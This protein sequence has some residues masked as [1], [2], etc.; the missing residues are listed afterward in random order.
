MAE[1]QPESQESNGG[2]AA[3]AAKRS[4][5]RALRAVL[6]VVGIVAAVG[7][8]YGNHVRRQLSDVHARH[9]RLL[10]NAADHVEQLLG[11]TYQNVERVKGELENLSSFVRSQPYLELSEPQRAR[12]EGRVLSGAQAHVRFESDLDG[13]EIVIGGLAR[14]DV[15]LRPEAGGRRI[16]GELWATAD[17]PAK[18]VPGADDARVRLENVREQLSLDVPLSA[19][20]ELG[21]ETLSLADEGLELGAEGEIGISLPIEGVS[22]SFDLPAPLERSPAGALESRLFLLDLDRPQSPE[23]DGESLAVRNVDQH[24]RLRLPLSSGQD[25]NLRDLKLEGTIDARP[26]AKDCGIWAFTDGEPR[27]LLK[28]EGARVGLAREPAWM[29]GGALRWGDAEA[30]RVELWAWK[31]RVLTDGALE[32][33]F[34][35][36]VSL[37]LGRKLPALGLTPEQHFALVELGAEARGVPPAAE[38][39]YLAAELAAAFD[40]FLNGLKSVGVRLGS[41]DAA[42][43]LVET[44]IRHERLVLPIPEGARE[45]VAKGP[46]D[47]EVWPL[48]D[49]SPRLRVTATSAPRLSGT[50]EGDDLEKLRRLRKEVAGVAPVGRLSVT[51]SLGDPEEPARYRLRVRGTVRHGVLELVSLAGKLPKLAEQQEGTLSALIRGNRL[52]RLRQQQ[53]DAEWERLAFDVSLKRLL[54]AL[55]SRET[56]PSYLIADG[57]GEVLIQTWEQPEIGVRT[58]GRVR[59]RSGLRFKSVRA[60]LEAE[61]ESQ[62]NP[63]IAKGTERESGGSGARAMRGTAVEIDRQ[64]A[65]IPMDLVCQPLRLGPLADPEE[66]KE[67][68]GWEVWQLCGLIDGE[69]A[70]REALVVSPYLAGGLG[71]LALLALFSMPILRFV[72]MEPH[73]RLRRTELGLLISGTWCLL[74]VVSL[75]VSAYH[76]HADFKGVLDAQLEILAAQVEANLTADLVAADELL[77]ILDRQAATHFDDSWLESKP[78]EV[79]LKTRTERGR[80]GLEIPGRFKGSYLTSVFWVDPS[81]QQIA[82]AAVGPETTAMISVEGREYFRAARGGENWSVGDGFYFQTYSSLTT[83]A[84]SAALARASTL[85]GASDDERFVVALTGIPPSVQDPLV[86]PPLGFAVI[87]R[88]GRT[89]FHSDS[90]R[91]LTANFFEEQGDPQ[92]LAAAMG[93]RTPVSLAGT[94][95]TR[96][97]ILHVRPLFEEARLPG[98]LPEWWIVTFFDKQL[99]ATIVVEAVVRS[100]IPTLLSGLALG[101]ALVVFRHVLLRA[102]WPSRRRR[103]RYRRIAA[104]LLLLALGLVM[105]LWLAPQADSTLQALFWFGLIPLLALI[106]TQLKLGRRLPSEDYDGKSSPAAKTTRD[107]GGSP[108]EDEAD[109]HGVL[110]DARTWFAEM[111]QREVF[112]R[113]T[114]FS[115]VYGFILLWCVVAILPALGY[116]EYAWS[117]QLRT[118]LKHDAMS[119]LE[120]LE[121]RDERSAGSAVDRADRDIYLFSAAAELLARKVGETLEPWRHRDWTEE[122]LRGLPT[123]NQ[124]ARSLR[125]LEATSPQR[126]TWVWKPGAGELPGTGRATLTR[127]GTSAA[128]TVDIPFHTLPGGAAGVEDP[129]HRLATLLMLGVILA[130]LAAWVWYIADRICFSRLGRR[131]SRVG[132]SHVVERAMGKSMMAV[133][134]DPKQSE[135]LVRE[136]RERAGDRLVKVDLAEAATKEDVQAGMDQIVLCTGFDDALLDRDSRSDMRKRL[137]RIVATDA[138]AVLLCDRSSFDQLVG[139]DRCLPPKGTTAKGT[140]LSEEEVRAWDPLLERF[141]RRYVSKAGAPYFVERAMGK[142]LIALFTDPKQSDS[143]VK[144]CRDRAGDCLLEIDLSAEDE[145]LPAKNQLALCRGFE[146]A[147]FDPKTRKEM[148]LR[149]ERIVATE[150]RVLLLCQRS[151]YDLLV[152][153]GEGL[154]AAGATANGT[155]LG[156]EEARSWAL[157]L[158]HFEKWYVAFD[159]AATKGRRDESVQWALWLA[160]GP[161]ERLTLLQLACEGMVNPRRYKTVESLRR[162]GLVHFRPELALFSTAEFAFRDFIHDNGD[163]AL[164]LERRLAAESTGY[165]RFR[166]VIWTAVVATAFFLFMTKRELFNAG[167]AVLGGLAVALPVLLRLLG[168][169][170]GGPAAQE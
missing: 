75:L 39:G 70:L 59:Q 58:K 7:L 106:G 88:T 157:L 130:A 73:E 167:I 32:V 52:V 56:F 64:L 55:P 125:Y 152:G 153:A 21:F 123:Y 170:R 69:V 140:L 36:E 100:L 127:P 71:V 135:D 99:P 138:R 117:S 89:L 126:A 166:W 164:Q 144:E 16:L 104:V 50:V 116:F 105:V 119:A 8:L 128:G 23:I 14:P 121:L 91:A 12:M 48:R 133:V 98:Q 124:A 154:A 110:A 29:D 15:L 143:L 6:I 165:G 85:G 109:D 147:L 112:G 113:G 1:N 137:E 54:D 53:V 93:S 25:E 82:K 37:D 142:S 11:L 163:L 47:V 9:V 41:P 149:L 30:N 114:S 96:P 61:A 145:Q 132:V 19:E 87:D 81:G 146:D 65:G 108:G 33:G 46:V 77:T 26:R 102:L 57:R 90:R 20:E 160:C 44:R 120:S 159:L 27:Q 22:R 122:L 60:L 45:L 35:C 139:A 13:L 84:R 155:S 18:I 129:A 95:Q 38:S 118:V 134:S 2:A 161:E 51:L 79:R 97:H 28:A 158:A 80:I 72:L 42:S 168:S 101:L 131:V 4:A 156:D 40:A 94:Y 76:R 115:Y 43:V 78:R 148:R 10:G 49:G 24:F 107:S 150:A 92:R 66:A 111:R 86:S 34:Y 5:P 141:D 17:D 169:L 74:V 162:R 31:R 68:G 3:G 62:T 67:Q 103:R 136:C 83:G 151:P 63:A